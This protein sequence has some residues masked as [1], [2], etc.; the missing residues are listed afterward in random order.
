QLPRLHYFTEMEVLDFRWTDIEQFL[1]Q[2]F[3]LR[4][5]D[6]WQGRSRTLQTN[7]RDNTALLALAANPLLLTQ[8]ALVFEKTGDVPP[9]RT[10]L[11][12]LCV[13]LQQTDC[14]A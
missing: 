5:P 1:D 3:Q 6:G 12:E 2:W 7:L 8:I 4:T 9:R 14:A 13:S 10:R 11:Y